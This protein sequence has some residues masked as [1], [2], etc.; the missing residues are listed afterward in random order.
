M[1][2]WLLSLL[3][4]M[5]DRPIKFWELAVLD[6]MPRVGSLSYGSI[7]VLSKIQMLYWLLSLLVRMGD[8][9]IKFWELAV[10]DIMPFV[11]SHSYGSIIVQN[12]NLVLSKES[13]EESAIILR[14]E[15]S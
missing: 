7:T 11:G 3:V 6:L 10:L 15:S 14:V 8:R 13:L 5:G 9:P 2:Y 1:L 4:R 12:R